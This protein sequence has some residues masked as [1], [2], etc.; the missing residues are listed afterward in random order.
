VEIPD[1]LTHS[2]P[3][4]LQL[5]RIHARLNELARETDVPPDDLDEELAWTLGGGVDPYAW[6]RAAEYAVATEVLEE[7]ADTIGSTIVHEFRPPPEACERR[8]RRRRP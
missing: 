4:V 7:V 8:R 5:M 3:L 2:G 1:E 6:A